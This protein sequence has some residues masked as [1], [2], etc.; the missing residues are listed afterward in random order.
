MT[1]KPIVLGTL[2]EAGVLLKTSNE[3]KKIMRKA[4]SYGVL[5]TPHLKKYCWLAVLFERQ[6]RRRS[7][8]F[9]SVEILGDIVI[10]M[11]SFVDKWDK[12]YLQ[13]IYFR[14]DYFNHQWKLHLLTLSHQWKD[15]YNHN[16]LKGQN[17]NKAM[18]WT[19]PGN[20]VEFWHCVY[21]G[22]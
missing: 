17:Q 7:K 6:I 19:K 1:S 18:W 9:D 15:P 21:S 2:S 11:Y 13:K 22:V 14:L 10:D 12:E 4:S 5:L 8:L 20:E 16:H 3:I